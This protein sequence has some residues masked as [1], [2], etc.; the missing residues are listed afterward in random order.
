MLRPPQRLLGNQPA[1]FRTDL[2][3]YSSA[4]VPL[5]ARKE[6]HNDS[7]SNTNN[8]ARALSNNERIIN[9]TSQLNLRQIFKLYDTQVRSS[10]GIGT[11]NRDPLTD[12]TFYPPEDIMNTELPKSLELI[13]DV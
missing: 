11:N 10:I 3:E 9:I 6:H 13:N 12:F 7:N 4:I 2:K 5:L 8:P 1:Q